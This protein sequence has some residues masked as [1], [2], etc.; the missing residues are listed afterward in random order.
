L[1]FTQLNSGLYIKHHSSA[2]FFSSLVIY[3]GINEREKTENYLHFVN[4]NYSNVHFSKIFTIPTNEA[5]SHHKLIT[6]MNEDSRLRGKF[7]LDGL[8]V[9]G[10]K[11]LDESLSD[12]LMYIDAK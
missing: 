4:I 1:T 12:D 8:I 9:F 10:G 6:T 11:K 7:K 2:T 3:G 5:R